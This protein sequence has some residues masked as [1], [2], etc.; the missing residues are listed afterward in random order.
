MPRET[1]Y[2]NTKAKGKG[3]PQRE[4]NNSRC[5]HLKSQGFPGSS[6]LADA[7]LALLGSES[8]CRAPHAHGFL[9]TAKGV[10]VHT[11]HT[12]L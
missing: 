6:S 3:W 11:Q 1:S 9:C 7:A 5:S 2:T 10:D 4:E 8:L 12:F